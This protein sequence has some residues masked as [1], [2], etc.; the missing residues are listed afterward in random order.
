[1]TTPEIEEL[2]RLIEERY[3]KQL[4]TTT[5]FEEFT[6]T[7]KKCGIAVS[8]S[9]MK[10]LYDY[11]GDSHK[12]RVATLDQLAVY[13]GHKSFSHFVK[14]LKNSTRY[15]SSFFDA[16]QLVSSDLE[17][18]DNVEIGWAPNR[19]LR[20]E[21]IGDSAYRVVEAH[22]SKLQSDDMFVTGCFIKEQPLYLPY[23]ERNGERTPPFVA[24]RNGGLSIVRK[25]I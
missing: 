6:L 25:I 22:N 10:R 12:P 9:T 17:R 7:L 4:C 3:G 2:K 24:G 1:M 11:V 21:Y 18:G 5:D 8:A 13:I 19:L 20:L 14:W 15:N 16:C 23:I